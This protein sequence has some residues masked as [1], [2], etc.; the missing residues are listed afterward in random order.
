MVTQLPNGIYTSGGE[1]GVQISGG[2]RQ[3]IAIARALYFDV[4]VIVFDEATSALDGISEKKIMDSIANFYGH[5][6]IIMIAHRLKT[7]EN[8]DVIFMLENGQIVDLGTYSELVS[9]NKKF[10]EM[11]QLS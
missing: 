11:A 4:D 9:K 7:I 5:K 6:T 8:C 1:R 10:Q 2:Q 3:R